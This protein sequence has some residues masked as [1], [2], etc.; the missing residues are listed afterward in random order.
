MPVRQQERPLGVR[1]VAL[2]RHEPGQFDV[3]ARQVIPMTAEGDGPGDAV[4]E[5]RHHQHTVGGELVAPGGGNVPGTHGDEGPIEWTEAGHGV[6]G[7]G[8]HDADPL[9]VSGSV[10]QVGSAVGDLTIDVDADHVLLAWLM[11]LI[12]DGHAPQGKKLGGLWPLLGS[13]AS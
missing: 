2:H 6:L 11:W 3:G 8:L 4:H 7:I 13:W 10:Q 5:Q 12:F 1:S 9:A